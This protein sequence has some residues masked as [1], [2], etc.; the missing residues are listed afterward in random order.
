MTAFCKT[1][2]ALLLMGVYDAQ[3]VLRFPSNQSAYPG[4]LVKVV[5]G[6]PFMD[7]LLPQILKLLPDL[8][9]T[10]LD[11]IHGFQ[12]SLTLE[13]GG[14]ATM[15]VG[16]IK[17]RIGETTWLTFPEILRSL[18]KDRRRLTYLKAIQALSSGI[19]LD[20]KVLE[21]EDVKNLLV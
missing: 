7:A 19:T 8:K 13:D 15:Y 3:G 18:P 1:E 5:P 11:M 17:R 20:T 12:E 10:E 14:E 6:L 4:L 16:T 21:G 9:P 2:S